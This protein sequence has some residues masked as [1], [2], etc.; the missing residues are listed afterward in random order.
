MPA[1]NTIVAWRNAARA[2]CVVIDPRFSVRNERRGDSERDQH[3]PELHDPPHRGAA[4]EGVRGRGEAERRPEV[5]GRRPSASF[6]ALCHSGKKSF[7]ILSFLDALLGFVELL[8]NSIL[9]R[10]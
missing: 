6:A 10:H 5:E 3:Q 1:V 8:G 7:S 9:L 4:N 2:L